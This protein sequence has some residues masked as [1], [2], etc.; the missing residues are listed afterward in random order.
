M[1]LIPYTPYLTP[2]SSLLSLHFPGKAV[3]EGNHEMMSILCDLFACSREHSVF[4]FLKLYAKFPKSGVLRGI[5]LGV[6]D[7]GLWVVQ[8]GPHL[9]GKQKGPA[10]THGSDGIEFVGVE[11]DPG[12]E[13]PG[14]FPVPAESMGRNAVDDP[15]DGLLTVTM[16]LENAPC[17]F[18]ARHGM[19]DLPARCLLL[20]S[21]YVVEVSSEPE[22]L[23][24]RALCAADVPA[25][26]P[27][28]V[29]VIPT[30]TARVGCEQRLCDRSDLGL[31][32]HPF[33]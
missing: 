18:G 5:R 33:P 13:R 14:S 28:T 19:A 30:V 24:I 27:D 21:A 32:H 25:K 12:L 20:R 10:Y 1:R 31:A 6:Q 8:P 22:N 2:S 16:L 23:E 9:A 26:V 29:R 15:F 7:V 4:D 3:K 11:Q 17:T